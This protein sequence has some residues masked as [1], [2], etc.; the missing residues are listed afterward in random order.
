MPRS[1]FK[2]ISYPF[3]IN[4]RGGVVMST[5][6]ATDPTHIAESLEQI[7][8]T[9]FLERPMESAIYSNIS[10]LL[11]E[12]NDEALQELLKSDI[13]D[14]IERLEERVELGSDDISFEVEVDNNGVEILY[15]NIT[16]RI[17]KYNTTYVSKI[18][19][20]EVTDE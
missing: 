10:R 5:T 3:R 4:S 12:P 2:G 6:S 16:Y 8:K 1:G 11:F 7:F 14:D 13:I 9:H 15:A 20:G 18:K 19:V 17:V